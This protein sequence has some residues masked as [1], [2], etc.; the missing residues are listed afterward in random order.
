MPGIG[1]ITNPNSRRNRRNPEQVRR[2]GYVLGRDASHELTRDT[3]DIYRVAELFR[4][5]EVEVLALNG[6]DGTNHVTLSTFID[7]YGD[8]PLPKI[9]FLR[10]GTMNTISNAIGIR[11]NPGKILLNISEKYHLGQPFEISERDIMRIE[12][13][14]HTHYGFIFGN[15]LAFNFLDL[16]YKSGASPTT[17]V[18]T[19][20][21]ICGSALVNGSLAREAFRPFRA[22]ITVDGETWPERE[23]TAVFGMA[24]E[25]IG[26]GFRPAL[27]CRAEPGTFNV[28]GILAGPFSFAIEMPKVRMGKPLPSEKMKNV[29]ARD[30]VFASDEPLEFTIDGDLHRSEGPVRI[31]TGPTLEIIVQ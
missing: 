16:Y 8:T 12:Y 5:E 7:V 29:I 22:E 1:I 18:T 31:T 10:G 4:A 9:A 28:L 20:C 23:F 24:I 6:G 11:G 17:A 25:Q 3:D 19:F 21:R 15:G 14:G 13:D 26:L 30:A 2:L 27:R